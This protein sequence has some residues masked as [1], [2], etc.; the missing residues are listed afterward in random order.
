MVE[1]LAT[2]MVWPDLFEAY[3]AVLEAAR[4]DQGLNLA[5]LRR[6]VPD[7]P[8]DEIAEKGFENLTPDQIAEVMI[9]PET[10]HALRDYIDE[11]ETNRGPWFHR[12]V[13]KLVRAQ[14]SEPLSEEDLH[15]IERVSKKLEL[16]EAFKKPHQIDTSAEQSKSVIPQTNKD[17]RKRMA[18]WGLAILGMAACLL[19]GIFLGT[20]GRGDFELSRISGDAEYA[21]RGPKLS[22]VTISSGPFKGYLTAVAILPGQPDRPVVFPLYPRRMCPSSQ[23][24]QRRYRWLETLNRQWRSC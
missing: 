14:E 21:V 7:I 10:L 2:M 22:D 24:S 12:L 6:P 18:G 11:P 8:W 20:R 19:I 17:S 15:R 1:L 4:A 13:D 3:R 23:G 9:R 5:L 16:S